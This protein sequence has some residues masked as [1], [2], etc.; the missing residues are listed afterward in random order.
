MEVLH[1]FGVPIEQGLSLLWFSLWALPL[2][3]GIGIA[4]YCIVASVLK[5]RRP[6]DVF[7]LRRPWYWGLL[8][9]VFTQLF[10]FFLWGF[11]NFDRVSTAL[12]VAG[13]AWI[14]G[15]LVYWVVTIV[16]SPVKVKYAPWFRRKLLS[17]IS[18]S[19]LN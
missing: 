12:S 3:A 6:L 13:I 8:V 14:F 11:F 17:G 9:V 4:A 15:V 16:Y 18:K 10:I 2:G 1:W 5:L 7:K 19:S